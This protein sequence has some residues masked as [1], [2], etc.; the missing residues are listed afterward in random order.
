MSRTI[1]RTEV[2]YWRDGKRILLPNGQPE[3]GY[4]PTSINAAK[5]HSRSLQLAGKIVRR[6]RP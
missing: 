1:R 6:G 3:E 5:R 4:K 2:D